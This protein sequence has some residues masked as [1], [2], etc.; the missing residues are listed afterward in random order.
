[1]GLIEK[2]VSPRLAVANRSNSLKSTGP[3]TELGKAHASRNSAKHSIFANVNPQTMKE[4]GENPAQFEELR[5]SL[6]AALAPRDGFEDMLI[7]DM[8]AIRWRLRRLRRAEAGLLVVQ[9][10]QFELRVRPGAK[11]QG[12]YENL[13]VATL[14]LVGGSECQEKYQQILRL[15]ISLSESV[16][17]EGFTPQGLE[18]LKTVYG[19]TPGVTG[20]GLTAQYKAQLERPKGEPETGQGQE[21]GGA[22]ESFLGSL[23]REMQAF[24]LRAKAVLQ[25][26]DMPLPQSAKDAQLIPSE[27]DMG[28]ILRYETSLERLLERKVQQLV[29]WRREKA[30]QGREPGSRSALSRGRDGK[31]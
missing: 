31:E 11:R 8:A 7:E 17:R 6:R 22:R 14:G 21:G 5:R 18:L 29:A 10:K 23:H 4:L 19:E 27:E 16:D 12:G 20:A 15:L 25:L 30:G 13:L 28:R 26:E 3:N 9:Q 2:K 1:M 24:T